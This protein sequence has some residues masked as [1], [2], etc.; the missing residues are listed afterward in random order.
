MVETSLHVDILVNEMECLNSSTLEV[1]KYILQSIISY[2]VENLLQHS[3]VGCLCFIWK[4]KKYYWEDMHISSVVDGIKLA[5][6]FRANL[7]SPISVQC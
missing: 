2:A 4:K 1:D 7:K 6:N 3:S 5:E